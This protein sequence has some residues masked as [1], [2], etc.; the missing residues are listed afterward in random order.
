MGHGVAI[1]VL[2]GWRRW[3]TGSVLPADKPPKLLDFDIAL[4][5]LRVAPKENNTSSTRAK[6]SSLH[7]H[8]ITHATE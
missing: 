4:I 7:M 1:Y 6:A 3:P 5:H 8:V 2:Q